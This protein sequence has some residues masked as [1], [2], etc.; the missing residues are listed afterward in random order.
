M[1]TSSALLRPLDGVDPAEVID[2]AAEVVEQPS[3]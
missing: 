3:E 2:R 1:T